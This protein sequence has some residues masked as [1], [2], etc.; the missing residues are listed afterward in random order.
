[1]DKEEHRLW[2]C[3]S[4]GGSWVR[5]GGSKD[6]RQGTG[7]GRQWMEALLRS[8]GTA[9]CA[10]WGGWGSVTELGEDAGAKHSLQRGAG[11]SLPL[12]HLSS[13]SFLTLSLPRHLRT[14]EFWLSSHYCPSP[15]SVNSECSS[16][17]VLRGQVQ[18]QL[19][20]RSTMNAMTTDC[21]E[22]HGRTESILNIRQGGCSVNRH[23]QALEWHAVIKNDVFWRLKWSWKFLITWV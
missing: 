13:F 19:P 18:C 3:I 22:S 10:A 8:G 11:A 7:T 20:R 4:E 9:R 16:S 15:V 6:V 1:M 14:A 21:A 2:E 23:T 5:G 17:S 12:Q